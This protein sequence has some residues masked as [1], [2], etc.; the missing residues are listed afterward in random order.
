[1]GSG[2]QDIGNWEVGSGKGDGGSSKLYIYAL[3]ME[4]WSTGGM[5]LVDLG[6]RGCWGFTDTDAALQARFAMDVC[7]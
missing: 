6:Q 2:S 3:A 5:A 1:M 4:Y 7:R